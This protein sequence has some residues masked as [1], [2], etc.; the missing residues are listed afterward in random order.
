MV[1]KLW[2]KT[3]TRGGQDVYFYDG[4]GPPKK[5]EILCVQIIILLTETIFLTQNCSNRC[6]EIK[7]KLTTLSLLHICFS[8]G[9][10]RPR[11]SANVLNRILIKNH[12]KQESLV[13]IVSFIPKTTN[14]IKINNLRKTNDF[15]TG[16]GCCFH[17]TR[18]WVSQM[19]LIV[20]SKNRFFCWNQAMF[21][22]KCSRGC[23]IFL[24]SVFIK[25]KMVYF[26][27]HALSL[28]K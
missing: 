16:Y 20:I 9:R 27:T 21:L 25:N 1:A 13:Q 8:V 23:G 11:N 10:C 6:F 2:K 19:I 12:P 7:K 22:K 24:Y 15:L 4:G 14:G 3:E 26:A 28:T 5:L 17:G 18:F